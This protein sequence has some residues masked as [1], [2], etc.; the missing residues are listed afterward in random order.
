MRF[1][2]M[3]PREIEKLRQLLQRWQHLKLSELFLLRRKHLAEPQAM[4]LH[5]TPL[6]L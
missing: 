2:M 1:L 5:Q 4:Q 6:E 3:T